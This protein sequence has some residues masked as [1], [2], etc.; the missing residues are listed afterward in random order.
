[1]ALYVQRKIQS[2]QC[3]CRSRVHLPEKQQ[4]KLN[5]GVGGGEVRMNFTKIIHSVTK[6]IDKQINNPEEE[7][8]TST[9]S[10]CNVLSKM[11]SS[12]QKILRHVKTR[13]LKKK[14]K[15]NAVNKTACE[16]D[17][18]S[19]L[20][21]KDYKV[22]IINMFRELKETMINEEK[23][24]MRTMWHPIKTTNQE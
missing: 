12:Q 23:K 20:S 10:C 8:D 7:G 18:M 17:Q 9:Q 13:T 21:G 22:A 24:D 1:M 2:C 3:H 16:K 14:K 6:Q 15:K 19:I 5:T 11:S 4:Q